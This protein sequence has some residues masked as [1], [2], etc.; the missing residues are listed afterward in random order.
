[1]PHHANSGERA[2]GARFGG[3]CGAAWLLLLAGG[4]GATPRGDLE[5]SRAVGGATALP[6]VE[7]IA[8]GPDG[9]PL[10]E[11]R[12]ADVLTL[13]EALRRAVTTDPSI[14]A[15][16]ARVRIAMAEADQARLLPNPVLD[17]V[18]RWGPGKAQIEASVA[19]DLVAVLQ[20]PRRASA[21]DHRLRAAVAEAVTVAI[22]TASEVRERYVNVQAAA[23]LG[24]V[25]ESRRLL[26]E[27][28]ISVAGARL[29]A[30]EGTR[31][32][33]VT[34]EA[35]RAELRVEMD[36]A[37]LVEREERLRLA[38]LIGEPSSAAVWALEPWIA[39]QDG[40]GER[41]PEEEWIGA[42]LR[43]RPEIQTLAW[44]LRALGDDA[45]VAALLA[46]EGAGA[47]VDV[48]REEGWYAGPAVSTPIPVFDTGQA[49]R[50]RV[51]AEQLE[52]RHELTLARRK[53]V[54]EVRVAYE[55]W[56]AGAANLDRVQ[57]ELIPLQQQRRALA[58]DAYRAGISDV[59]ELFLAEQDLR[60]AEEKAIEV[61]QQVTSAFFRLERAVGGPG[62]ASALVAQA[63]V[64]GVEADKGSES[65]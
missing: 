52:A 37:Q 57:R 38:R 42:A 4:C 33:L 26:V 6:A 27:R 23:A 32:D 17:V 22:D 8:V 30:G 53:V 49:A 50:A 10:D 18:L 19:Q 61:Q 45:A 25:L 51:R 60:L 28:M 12:A 40:G 65:E 24:P 9:G 13:R 7:F 46:W 59:T 39:A 43:Q 58:E 31:S 14:Q 63:A 29:E 47:G 64:P 41:R 20:R 48:T 21:A 36:R 2:V 15:A 54:E 11:A 16:M 5:V 3:A 34:L 44:R 55:L 1:M 56:T 35:Q 62:P